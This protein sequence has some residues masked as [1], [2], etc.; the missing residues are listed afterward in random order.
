M[1]WVIVYDLLAYNF[2]NV[3]FQA[4]KN[5]KWLLS[6]RKLFSFNFTG[7]YSVFQTHVNLVA[8]LSQQTR[9]NHLQL[10]IIMIHLLLPFSRPQHSFLANFFWVNPSQFIVTKAYIKGFSFTN[11]KFFNHQWVTFLIKH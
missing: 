3:F 4:F 8:I 6:T 7:L 2:T 1:K 9:Y 11:K 10:Q 5:I